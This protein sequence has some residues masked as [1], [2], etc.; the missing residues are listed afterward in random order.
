MQAKEGAMQDAKD[1]QSQQDASDA[2]MTSRYRTA[3]G[4]WRNCRAWQL[5]VR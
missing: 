1:P 4:S 5:A 2:R 3:K